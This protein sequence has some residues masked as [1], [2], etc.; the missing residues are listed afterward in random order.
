MNTI[1]F[2]LSFQLYILKVVKPVWQELGKMS[3]AMNKNPMVNGKNQQKLLS[4]KT[5]G[6]KKKKAT[7]TTLC[8]ISEPLYVSTACWGVEGIYICAYVCYLYFML[9]HYSRYEL[10]IFNFL[11]LTV[12]VPALLSFRH[13]LPLTRV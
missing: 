8:C 9:T 6:K 2:L 5:L 1:P 4:L 11:N 3:K 10:Y 7:T 12:N 13:M